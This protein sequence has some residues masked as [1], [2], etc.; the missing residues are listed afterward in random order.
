MCFKSSRW[1]FITNQQT[2]PVHS[3]VV[4]H[5]CLFKFSIS[6]NYL[7]ILVVIFR[8]EF[9]RR[10]ELGQCL[11]LTIPTL[12][13][14]SSKYVLC[15]SGHYLDQCNCWPFVITMFVKVGRKPPIP[16]TSVQQ[17]LPSVRKA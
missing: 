16:T 12:V 3:N 5:L 7:S 17:T 8:Q 10:R 15:T 9:E 11:E 14:I 1:E 13:S 4:G 2:S 6:K